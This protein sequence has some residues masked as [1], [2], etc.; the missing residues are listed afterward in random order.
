MVSLCV[1]NYSNYMRTHRFV[2]N[3]HV[4]RI[5]SQISRQYMTFT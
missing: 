2:V 5:H 3:R 4:V 1:L